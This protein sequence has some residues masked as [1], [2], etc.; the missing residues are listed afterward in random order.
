MAASAT[1]KK[2]CRNDF[3]VQ[4]SQTKDLPEVLRLMQEL[5]EYENLPET[6]KITLDELLQDHNDRYYCK[7]VHHPNDDSI[8]I[9]YSFYFITFSTWCGRILYMEDLYVT[10]EFRGF[11]IGTK[12]WKSILEH[13]LSRGC[14]RCDW[15]VLDWN[16][17][18]IDYYYSK[19]AIDS[20]LIFMRFCKPEMESISQQCAKLPQEGGYSSRNALKSDIPTIYSFLKENH[21]PDMVE[22]DVGTLEEEGFDNKLYKCRVVLLNE[23]IVACILYCYTYGWEGKSMFMQDLFVSDQHRSKGIGKYL[24]HSMIKEGVERGNFMCNLYVRKNDDTSYKYFKDLK[25]KDFSKQDGYLNF[26]MKKPQM[27]VFK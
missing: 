22:I 10:S 1:D 18:A 5:G 23:E 8:L 7:V 13:G 12:I 4:D 2:Y 9:G 14:Q 11:G 15:T 26:R 25:A 6:V 17:S 16:K 20:Q 24:V 21:S 19:G 3:I 27:L